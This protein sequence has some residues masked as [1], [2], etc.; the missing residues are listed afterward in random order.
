M[1]VAGV[2]HDEV[3][4]DPDAACVRLRDELAEVGQGAE[5]GEDLGVVRDVVAAVAQRARV[6]RRDPQAV[7]AEPLEVVEPVD[8]PGEVTLPGALAVAERAHQDL[9]EHGRAE[10]LGVVSQTRL[11]GA[12][13]GGGVA[14]P[15]DRAH[16][17]LPRE[18]M[19]T[20]STSGP[21]RT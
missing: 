1:L 11:V 17:R 12:E 13:P 5:V 19:C 16:A 10:P 18:T 7:H 15:G 14:H 8:D 2:V 9:V 4:D 6:E 21:N 20:G 3:G